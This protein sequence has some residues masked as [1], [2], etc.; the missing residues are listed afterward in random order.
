VDTLEK[1]LTFLME[2]RAPSIPDPAFTLGVMARIE[3]RRFRRELMRHFVIAL[4]AG[5]TLFL[6][7]P[8]LAATLQG[9]HENALE[10]LLVIGTALFL[11]HWSLDK[12]EA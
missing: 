9:I 2:N 6:L 1:Q 10:T 8:G 7:S 11:M 5:A 12:M 4:A 3:K